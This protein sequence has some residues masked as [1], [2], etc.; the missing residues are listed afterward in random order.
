VAA[1]FNRHAQVRNN[2]KDPVVVTI[3]ERRGM[4][5]AIRRHAGHP[6]PAFRIRCH[7]DCSN[8]RNS[9]SSARARTDSSISTRGARFSRQSRNLASVFIFM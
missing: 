1:V 3:S 9:G 4:A 6:S 7:F 5:D 2:G 8:I